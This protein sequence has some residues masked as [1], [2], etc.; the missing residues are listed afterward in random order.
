M[1]AVSTDNGS[2]SA[3]IAIQAA[4]V[5]Q[6]APS[7]HVGEATVRVST[8]HWNIITLAAGMWLFVVISVKHLIQRLS[9]D[10]MG[11]QYFAGSW[12]AIDDGGGGG[13]LQLQ[14][15]VLF[16][17]WQFN[18]AQLRSSHH[19]CCGCVIIFPRLYLVWH[20][21][22]YPSSDTYLG[23][24]TYHVTRYNPDNLPRTKPATTSSLLNAHVS[25]NEK[26]GQYTCIQCQM[27]S[28]TSLS[29]S[30][31]HDTW[32]HYQ[33]APHRDTY[34]ETWQLTQT[35]LP[36]LTPHNVLTF[37]VWCFLEAIT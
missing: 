3:S 9:F 33:P 7:A 31:H 22:I 28:C 18:L 4:T 23:L 14:D 10:R 12:G 6:P 29:A 19:H 5:L 21:D 8:Q 37:T 20:R 25:L 1:A 17:I 32:R 24:L 15:V 30:P 27:L 16:I 2:L 36:W 11:I 34:L 13:A 26:W 35:W